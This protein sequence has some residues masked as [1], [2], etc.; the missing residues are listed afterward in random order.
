[1][2]SDSSL[3]SNGLAKYSN[4][5][6]DGQIPYKQL[7]RPNHIPLNGE[8]KFPHSFDIVSYRPNP[9]TVLQP[10]ANDCHYQTM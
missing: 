3:S 5:Y 8:N 6:D 10:F 4:G 9:N 7:T 2:I 1:M